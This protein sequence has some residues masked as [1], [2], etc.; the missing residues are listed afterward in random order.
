MDASTAAEKCE[1]SLSLLCL[2]GIFPQDATSTMRDD[3]GEQDA[4]LSAFI[5]DPTVIMVP[6]PKQQSASTGSSE[7]GSG[8]AWGSDKCVVMRRYRPGSDD[9]SRYQVVV[10]EEPVLINELRFAEQNV[11]YETLLANAPAGE[12]QEHYRLHLA[13]LKS[14]RKTLAANGAATNKLQGDHLR[15]HLHLKGAPDN[16]KSRSES[17]RLKEGSLAYEKA[18]KERDKLRACERAVARL[19]VRCEDAGKG[20]RGFEKIDWQQTG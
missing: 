3:K 14:I 10:S 6:S 19:L 18:A 9:D 5:P 1:N 16:A 13:R 15:Q 12:V 20:E 8:R 17:Q 7:R 2:K 4:D 11:A